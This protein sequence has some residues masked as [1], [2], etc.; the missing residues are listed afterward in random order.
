MPSYKCSHNPSDIT[1]DS[2]LQLACGSQVYT[3]KR[4][5]YLNEATWNWRLMKT[6]M[7]MCHVYDEEHNYVAFDQLAPED[8]KPITFL[9]KVMPDY[10]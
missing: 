6:I 7:T 10:A 9:K 2:E 1:K 4:G 5:K 8:S 3:R